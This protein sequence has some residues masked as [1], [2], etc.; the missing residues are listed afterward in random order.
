MGKILIIKGAD[1]SNNAL[2]S[3]IKRTD[4]ISSENVG[5]LAFRKYFNTIPLSDNVTISSFTFFVT[6][7]T[8]MNASKESVITIFATD[9]SNILRSSTVNVASIIN[10]L[11]EGRV[12]DREKVRVSLPSPLKIYAGEY[13]GICMGGANEE[14]SATTHNQLMS[15]VPTPSGNYGYMQYVG[16][17]SPRPSNIAVDLYGNID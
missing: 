7:A 9:G 6:L 3:I 15:Y 16:A 13:F 12:S 14:A 17:T 8:M 10:D 2:A 4:S 1:F 5:N 11:I